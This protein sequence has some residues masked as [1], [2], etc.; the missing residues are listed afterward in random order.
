MCGKDT[1]PIKDGKYY[2]T[3]ALDRTLLPWAAYYYPFSKF[4]LHL[5]ISSILNYNRSKITTLQCNHFEEAK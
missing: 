4:N 1:K 3:I 2:N 5:N